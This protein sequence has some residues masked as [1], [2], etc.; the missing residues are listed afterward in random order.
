MIIDNKKDENWNPFHSSI[1]DSL[2]QYKYSTRSFAGIPCF[3]SCKSQI[4]SYLSC[5]LRQNIRLGTS[6]VWK[7]KEVFLSRNIDSKIYMFQSWL[8]VNCF[9][10]WLRLKISLSQVQI[11]LC[12]KQIFIRYQVE[13]LATCQE[14]NN[15]IW[16]NRISNC[17]IFS[18]QMDVVPGDELKMVVI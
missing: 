5:F 12:R 10:W 4:A 15:T 16:N 2:D 18:C 14:W 11:F 8:K 17:N 3:Q 9:W 6:K 13:I 1:T 7:I